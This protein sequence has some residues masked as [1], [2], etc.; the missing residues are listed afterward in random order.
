VEFPKSRS[1]RSIARSL[2]RLSVKWL[3]PKNPFRRKSLLAMRH[4]FP[5]AVGEKLLDA[6]FSGLTERK[7][8]RLLRS[9]AGLFRVARG[10]LIVHVVPSNVPNPSVTSLILG[11]LARGVNAVKIS[12]RDPG[13]LRVYHKSLR[14]H[15]PELARVVVIFSSHR[16]VVRRIRAAALIVAYGNDDTIAALR[17]SAPK[18]VPFVGHGHRVSVAV[19]AKETL[20]GRL[21]RDAATDAWM[22]DRRGCMSPDVFFVQ[23]GGRMSAQEFAARLGEE[24]DRLYAGGAVSFARALHLKAARDRERL[25][26]AKG[27]SVSTR[28]PVR[29]FRTFRDLSRALLLYQGKLQVVALE[30]P[31]VSRKRLAATFARL[32]A[33]RIC[34]AGRMQHPPLTWYNQIL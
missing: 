6:L 29:I 24:L 12:K 10:S 5:G 25:R 15:D 30:A 19:F 4:D 22:M 17:R 33:S 23:D 34:R 14:A 13:L 9:D 28:V 1:A 20:N 27:E 32:G 31:P 2:G 18:G 11:L 26:A 7:L 21:A 8:I 16:E 3:N